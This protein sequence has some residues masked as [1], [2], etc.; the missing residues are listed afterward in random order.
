MSPEQLSGSELDSR[1]D[2]Y[3]AG[4][5][6]FECLTGRLPFEAETT[7][8]LIAKHLEE[9]PPDCR[10][11]NPE[12]PEGLALVI[13]RAMSRQAADRFASAGEMHKGLETLG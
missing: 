9:D 5:V 6:L 1:S 7:W 13:L 8:S 11:M 2:L 3:S 10:T 12:V 4:V